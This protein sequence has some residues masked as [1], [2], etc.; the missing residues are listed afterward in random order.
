[1]IMGRSRLIALKMG[2]GI[3]GEACAYIVFMVPKFA[4]KMKV[5]FLFLGPILPAVQL[6][7]KPFTHRGR[8][9][10]LKHQCI[11]DRNSSHLHY[12]T[13]L[14][15]NVFASGHIHYFAPCKSA[16]NRYDSFQIS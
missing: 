8:L 11:I 12:I 7:Q 14:Y 15:D 3:A 16:D 6:Q 5:I 4:L 9:Q 1:M 10:S 2:I 13:F